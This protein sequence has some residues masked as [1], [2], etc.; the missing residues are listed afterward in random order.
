MLLP[1]RDV[2]V[3]S[4]PPQHLRRARPFV[5]KMHGF[6]WRGTVIHRKIKSFGQSFTRLRAGVDTF[7]DTFADGESGMAALASARVIP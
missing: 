1:F 7:A 6:R 2:G 5:K 3:T 4:K